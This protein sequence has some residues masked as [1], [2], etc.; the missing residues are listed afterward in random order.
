M[1]RF[2]VIALALTALLLAAQVS[3]GKTTAT[4]AQEAELGNIFA[5]NPSVC[6][7]LQQTAGLTQCLSIAFPNSV[8]NGGNRADLLSTIDLVQGDG[9]GQIERS[10]LAGLA[11]FTGNHIHT[12][13]GSLAILVFVDDDDPV[14][15]ETTAGT[16]LINPV[17][18]KAKEFVCGTAE[19][20]TLI[21][22][23]DCDHDGVAGDGV[24]FAQLL[25]N[26]EPIG[27]KGR[28]TA[29]N[30]VSGE[31]YG[32]FFFE[33]VGE[34]DDIS[35]GAFETTVGGALPDINGDTVV[36]G[37]SGGDCPLPGGTAGFLAAINDPN[38]TVIFGRVQDKTGQNIIGSWVE[39]STDD[40]SLG[41]LAAP[42]TPTLNL[43]SFGFGAPQV[44]CGI[45]GAG[46]VTV[47]GKIVTGALGL[48]LDP[49]I[50]PDEFE[51]EI[52]LLG[53]PA[54]MNLTVTPAVL[55]CDGVA[56]ATVSA[57]VLT[58]A[59]E[60][61]ANGTAVGWSVQ[62]L[63]TA[64]PLASTVGD[65]TTKTL[66]TPFAAS[67]T[68]VPVV[69]SVGPKT[70]ITHPLETVADG[71]DDDGD[72]VVDDR[73]SATNPAEFDAD[74]DILVP[75]PDHFEASTLVVCGAGSGAGAG[76]TPGGQ[77]GAGST[78]P[79]GTIAGPD[80]GTGGDID[81]RGALGVWP[82]VA[83]FVA[84]MALAGARFGL[85]RAQ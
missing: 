20:S 2:G 6:L 48:T 15:F 69:A 43:G 37:G 5:L 66:V 35:L 51:L 19:T 52:T 27:T 74:V 13:D 80:T 30:T 17:P 55:N 47:K 18:F 58:A 21:G 25:G 65:G 84:A 32:D 59:G 76:T 83:L 79:G 68:G 46:T 33:V 72:T 71:S 3:G 61:A 36:R 67:D 73:G 45:G 64:S 14:K 54:T 12:L 63:G 50:Q 57:N 81:G 34:A 42:Q 29:Y 4:R 38:K 75:N 24:L 9:D 77:P 8:A 44:F 11:T 26:G 49:N 62:V 56:G 28:V 7:A 10:E 70:L 1:K 60:N 82:V 22:D 23:E 31:V 78:A 40:P 39:W 53:K 41:I 16:F 85:K